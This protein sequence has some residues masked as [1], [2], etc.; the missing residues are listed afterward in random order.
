MS[1]AIST[2]PADQKVELL[3]ERVEVGVRQVDRARVVVET[4]VETRQHAVEAWLDHEEVQVERVPVGTVI[5]AVPPVREE[6]GV[7]IVPVVEERLVMRTELVLKEELRIT[8]TVRKQ[9]VRQEVP[10][11]SEHATIRREDLPAASETIKG[12]PK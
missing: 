1:K 9:L 5:E 8:R 4:Q 11:R 3:E 10:L 7:V 12:E 6:G 2:P